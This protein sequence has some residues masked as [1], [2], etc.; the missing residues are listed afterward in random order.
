MIIPSQV[1]VY[2]ISFENGKS[3]IGQSVDMARRVTSHISAS[4]KGNTYLA[5]AMR[6]HAYQ[7]KCLLICAEEDLDY[8]EEA[9]IRTF[10]TLHPAGYNLKGGGAHG[11]PSEITR[12]KLKASFTEERRKAIG[13]RLSNVPLSELH[14]ERISLG[15]KATM[16]GDRLRQTQTNFAG[17]NHTEETKRRIGDKQRGIPRGP[18]SEE[19][20]AK[21]SLIHKARPRM[22]LSEETKHKIAHTL[23]GRKL[24]ADQKE[25]I[26]LAGIGRTHSETT[27]AK[28]RKAQALRRQLERD[29]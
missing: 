14:R 21:L 26:R 1:G 12:S 23:T 2:Q 7:I 8:Y 10:K 24:S 17:K 4:N 11:R 18:L 27:K 25:K 29:K 5:R 13:S 16:V 6:K 20:R 3:Y 15:L 9:A 28:M 22:P 19:H